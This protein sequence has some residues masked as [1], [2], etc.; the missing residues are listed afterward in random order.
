LFIFVRFQIKIM[1]YT[2][3]L[4]VLLALALNSATAQDARHPHR[5]LTDH[6]YEQRVAADP[7][8]KAEEE[9]FTQQVQTDAKA[10]TKTNGVVRIIPVVFHVFHVNGRE[11]ISKEQIDD[12]MRILN[13]DLRL[14]NPNRTAI[15]PMFAPLA[16]DCEIEFRLAN[17]DPNGNCFDGIN[18]I[19]STLTNNGDD[20]VKSLVSSTWRNGKYFN[21]YV[22]AQIKDT[23][24]D[25]NTTTLGYAQFPFGGPVNTRGVVIRADYVGT[26]G[27]SSKAKGG[28]T[29][30]HEVG[31]CFGLLHTFQGGCSSSSQGGDAVADTPPAADQNFGNCSPSRNTCTN[32]PGGDKPDMLQNYMDYTDGDCQAL[33]TI[34]QRDRM[35]SSLASYYATLYSASN[36]TATG[37]QNYTAPASTTISPIIEGFESLSNGFSLST[38][39][40]LENLGGNSYGWRVTDSASYGGQKSIYLPAFFHP[41]AWTRYTYNFYTPSVNF[42]AA[43]NMYVNFNVAYAQRIA[44]FA[45]TL[46]IYVSNNCGL[47]WNSILRV[48]GSQLSTTSLQTSAFYPA[49]KS[50]WKSFTVNATPYKTNNVK[51][52]FEFTY[53]RGNNIFIDDINVSNQMVS[54][55]FAQPVL[56]QVELYPNPSD[57]DAVLEYSISEQQDVAVEIYDLTG[58]TL[59]NMNMGNLQAGKHSIRIS[60]VTGKEALPMGMYLVRLR[61]GAQQHIS[62]LLISR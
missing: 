48:G 31:H 39:W 46:T 59:G 61:A 36:L 38:D 41:S 60:E 11:N 4:F 3:T 1:K 30:T 27:T 23:D 7:S 34:G 35:N 19:F 2:H 12:Q 37:V 58:K 21:I 47:T 56:Q 52:R 15:D 24:N 8:I 29:L 33:F 40:E 5:C 44:T 49:S 9:R 57:A 16:A 6:L 43:S 45:D 51:F 54:S 17:R 18:R 50:Q 13:E 42:N 25:P 55:A 28:R 26:I 53:L 20:A 32:D 62:K 14:L 10:R 22:V